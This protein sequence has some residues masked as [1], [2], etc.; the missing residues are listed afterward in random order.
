LGYNDYIN[1]VIQ[2]L[3]HVSLLRNYFLVEDFS[4]N[5]NIE[6]VKRFGTLIRRM[7]SSQNFKNQVSPHELLQEISSR[8]KKKFRIGARDNPMTFIS[9]LLNTMHQDMGGTKKLSTIISNCFRGHVKVLTEKE[10]SADETD[11]HSSVHHAKRLAV[12]AKVSPFFFLSLDIPPTPLFPDDKNRNVTIP[13]EP[14]YTLLSKFDGVTR[15]WNPLTKETKI[16]RITK[17]PKYIIMHIQRFT[18]NLWYQEKNQ[19]IVTFP[20]KHLDLAPYLEQS[21][22]KTK[23]PVTTSYNLIANIRHNGTPTEFNFNCHIL[24]KS[25]DKWYDIQDLIVE[26]AMPPLI[27]LS[28]AYIQVYERADLYRGADRFS[29]NRNK[30]QMKKKQ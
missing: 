27:A 7:W 19:T 5:Q 15:H 25:A 14:L 26:E 20:L 2:M 29:T 10:E 3:S 28:E 4:D 17:L 9:W 21:D 12:T 13:S 30:Q 16:Y 23:S 18:H 1:V 22:D 24:Q 6:L 11:H 8:S